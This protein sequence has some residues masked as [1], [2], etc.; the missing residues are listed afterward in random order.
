MRRGIHVRIYLLVASKLFQIGKGRI[1]GSLGKRS[2]SGRVKFK[3][4]K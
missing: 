1:F 4:L 3:R 2:W